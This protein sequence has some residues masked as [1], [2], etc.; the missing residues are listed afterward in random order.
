MSIHAYMIDEYKTSPL[1]E[2][3]AHHIV[4]V[5]AIIQHA[6]VCACM[7]CSGNGAAPNAIN[8]TPSFT[9]F[10]GNI[11]ALPLASKRIRC[12]VVPANA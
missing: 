12:A 3:K 8:A 9:P 10:A 1:I 7:W 6:E 4:L 2:D 11:N 5:D